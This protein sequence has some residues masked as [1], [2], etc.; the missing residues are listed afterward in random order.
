MTLD[1]LAPADLRFT[2]EETPEK[3]VGHDWD[4]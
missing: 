2:E 3:D 1:D 4:N